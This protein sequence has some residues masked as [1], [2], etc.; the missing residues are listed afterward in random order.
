M[1][2]SS[3]FPILIFSKTLF[4]DL[5]TAITDFGIFWN[6]FFWGIIFPLFIIFLFWNTAKK[7]NYL[8]SKTTYFQACSLFSYRISTKIIIALFTIYIIGLFTNGIS[9]VTQVQIYDRILFSL[10]T[11]LFLSFILIIFTFFS[12]LIIIKTRQNPSSTL[13]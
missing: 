8:S 1:I 10:L 12:S 3:I 9:V 5:L 2:V 6:P 4:I 13:N 7:I 11:I